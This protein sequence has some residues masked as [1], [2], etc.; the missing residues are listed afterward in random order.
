MAP[1]RAVFAFALAASFFA[2][3]FVQRVA[4]SVIVGE[5][6]AEFAVGAAVLGNLAAFYF[7]AYVPMQ[8]PVGML[9]DRFG[10]RRL[11]GFAAAV[12]ALGAVVFALAPTIEIAY[13]GR[14]MVGLGSAF[15]WIGILTVA[16]LWLP[17]QRFALLTGIAQGI[18]MVGAV[19]GQAPLA[20]AVAAFGWR[21][22]LLF[23]ALGGVALAIAILL[24]VEDKRTASGG[25]T[26]GF[27]DGM[28]AVMRAPNAWLAAGYG[29]AMTGTM[30]AFAG[31]WAVP[32][33]MQTKEFERGSA[34]LM[35]SLM[36]VGWGAGSPLI[37]YVVDRVRADR[38]RAMTAL[39]VGMT[40]SLAAVLYIPALPTTALA[41]LMV[42]NG[43]CASGMILCYGHAR[44]H[45]PADASSSA[46]GLVNT[47][48]VGSGGTLQ[49]TIGWLLD[50]NW[51]G[52][53][54]AGARIY[55]PEAYDRAFVVLLVVAALGT[56]L[57]LFMR[58]PTANIPTQKAD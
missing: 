27:T 3:A 16:T 36:F 44:D 12:A 54:Q 1:G 39:G 42:A 20:H 50:R 38:I 21:G 8:M 32:W 41:V 55:A 4:P 24:V 57:T 19:F 22:T 56:A 14:F 17:P 2:Y 45:A 28:R 13:L 34:A 33:L 10:P 47:A 26:S 48:V 11:M 7:Y 6:M 49:P 58:A 5:L 9:M 51:D 52:A 31:L 18:G 40:A 37:G 25:G 35:A 29:F 23:L 53:M 30:L 43:A 15:S 46:Y